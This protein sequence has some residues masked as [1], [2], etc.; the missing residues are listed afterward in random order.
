MTATPPPTNAN[1]K[2]ADRLAFNIIKSLHGLFG[3]QYKKGVEHFIYSN[4]TLTIVDFVR[5]GVNNGVIRITQEADFVCTRVCLGSRLNAT[6]GGPVVG[7]FLGTSN[8]IPVAGDW[9]DPSFRLQIIDGGTDRQLHDQAV[10]AF[11]AY[12]NMGGLPGIWSKPRLFDRNS[13]IRLVYEL[14]KTAANIADQ[15]E[16]ETLFIGWKIYDAKSQ[17]LTARRP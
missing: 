1:E 3:L 15:L 17:D 2:F 5:G 9:P 7:A 6:A 11:L 10:D 16:L 12:G 4:R 13:V 14:L 8:N